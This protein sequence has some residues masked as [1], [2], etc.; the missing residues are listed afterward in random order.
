MKRPRR[1]PQ[2]VWRHERRREEEVLKAQQRGE[3]VDEYG[4]VILIVSGTM[5]QLNLV[6]GHIWSLC[7]GSRE[8]DEVVDALAEEFAVERGELAEDVVEFI[9]DLESRGWLEY[10]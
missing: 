10:V 7:D 5:H 8:V 1:N 3:S 2:I 6:G 9:A 4:T